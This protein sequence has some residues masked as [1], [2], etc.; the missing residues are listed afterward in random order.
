MRFG[1]ASTQNRAENEGS[2]VARSGTVGDAE[3]AGFAVAKEIRIWQLSQQ[4]LR[5]RRMFVSRIGAGRSN[6]RLSIW[7]G[8][9]IGAMSDSRSARR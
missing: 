3:A 5:S 1:A 2:R 6:S 8:R 9:A 4:L 7:H